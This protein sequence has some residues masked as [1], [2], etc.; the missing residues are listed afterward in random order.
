M[1]RKEEIMNKALKIKA[2]REGGQVKRCHARPDGGR[3]YNVAIHSYNMLGLLAVLYPSCSPRLYRAVVWHD[4]PE[5][6]IGDIPTPLKLLQPELAGL[7]H[8][9]EEEIFEI[10]DVDMSL[11]PEEE[12]WLKA[13]DITEL[14]LWAREEIANKQMS[15]VELAKDC[16]KIIKEL[17]EQDKFPEPIKEYVMNI[18][19]EGHRFMPDS[20]DYLR[21]QTKNS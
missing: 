1:M 12:I 10:L 3:S 21:E 5:R 2:I 8:S 16:F 14:W 13:V 17:I 9:A 18:K 11:T 7:I 15:N 20:V 6:W 19:N 4:V